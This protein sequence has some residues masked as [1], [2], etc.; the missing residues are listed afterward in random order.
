MVDANLLISIRNKFSRYTTDE[1][2]YA[3]KD[4]METM[5]YHV[6]TPYSEKLWAEIDAA[7]ARL[8]KLNRSNPCPHC[9]GTGRVAR[10]DI[11]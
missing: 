6:G 10:L 4:C 5:K 7:N 11:G 2:N 1:C 9:D 3:K 8:A